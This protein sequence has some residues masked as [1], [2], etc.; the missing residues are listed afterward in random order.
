MIF[1]ITRAPSEVITAARRGMRD[2][3][4]RLQLEPKQDLRSRVILS[5]STKL[6]SRR[7]DMIIAQGNRSA[8]LALGYYHA[9]PPGRR[10]RR[11]R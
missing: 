3:K 5:R 2:S 7:D 1:D 8:A 9:A 11:T 4:G 10:K 6:K